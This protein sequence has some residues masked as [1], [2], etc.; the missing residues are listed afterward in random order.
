MEFLS[1]GLATDSYVDEGI[2]LLIGGKKT[3]VP[4]AEDPSLIV[5]VVLEDNKEDEFEREVTGVE[6][7]PGPEDDDE[8]ISES[9]DIPRLPLDWLEIMFGESGG[10]LIRV[11][12]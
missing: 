7:D 8:V 1:A 4:L 6:V 9:I 2:C 11:G 12:F 5:G 3:P 10:K